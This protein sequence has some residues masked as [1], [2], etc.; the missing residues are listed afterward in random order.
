MENQEEILERI[1]NS[2]EVSIKDPIRIEE[3]RKVLSNLKLESL[4]TIE[5][6]ESTK[7]L[8]IL[9]NLGDILKNIQPKMLSI[10]LET[11]NF[12]IHKKQK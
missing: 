7:K 8:E 4:I 2:F 10:A 12:T 3:I 9:E 1:V 5:S 6:F 11:A